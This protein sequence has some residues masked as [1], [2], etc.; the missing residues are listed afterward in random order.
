MNLK[1]L[2]HPNIVK[3]HE[4]YIDRESEHIYLI[5]ELIQGKEMFKVLKKEGGYSGFWNN[6]IYFYNIIYQ[7]I[8]SFKDI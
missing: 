1:T 4:L 8:Y 6:L 7:R 3:M 2:S 5:M